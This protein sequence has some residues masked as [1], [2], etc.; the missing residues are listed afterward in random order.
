MAAIYPDYAMS[1]LNEQWVEEAKVEVKPA[2]EKLDPNSFYKIM[3]AFA[4]QWQEEKAAEEA[5]QATAS[6][7]PETG[8][9]AQSTE[10]A[11]GATGSGAQ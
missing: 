7:A 11:P 6:P 2:Y 1:K 10:P 4:E 8:T 5:A 9:P 3:V